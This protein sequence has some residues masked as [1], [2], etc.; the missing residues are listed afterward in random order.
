MAV[1]IYDKIKAVTC[2]R[3]QRGLCSKHYANS[4]CL[5]RIEEM[6]G[7]KKCISSQMMYNKHQKCSASL[8]RTR[9]KRESA[10][11]QDGPCHEP[12]VQEVQR[13]V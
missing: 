5:H 13:S 11:E 1:R 4:K 9:R 2:G 12:G 6:Q 3:E 7:L 10:R 8:R